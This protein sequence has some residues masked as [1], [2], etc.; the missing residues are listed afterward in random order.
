VADIMRMLHDVGQAGDSLRGHLI[1]DEPG[2]AEHQAQSRE[3][4]KRPA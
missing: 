2:P 3:R 1:R 4:G